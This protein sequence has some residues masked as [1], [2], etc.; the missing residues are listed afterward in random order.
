[1]K[2][3]DIDRLKIFSIL[4]I[5]YED[6]DEESIGS[7]NPL[8]PSANATGFKSRFMNNYVSSSNNNSENSD[9][10]TIGKR[11]SRSGYTYR[12]REPSP[13]EESAGKK[14]IFIMEK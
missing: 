1:M 4:Q 3:V 7:G 5:A 6:S 12:T 14:Y 13:E 11:T 8:S 2:I 9:R 10:T